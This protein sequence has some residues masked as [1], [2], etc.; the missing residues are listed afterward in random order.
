MNKKIAVLIMSAGKASR[1]GSCKQLVIFNNKGNNVNGEKSTILQHVID[2][3]NSLFQN[4][5]QN[6]VFV[7]TGH[8]HNEIAKQ[9]KST[10][11][12]Y[13]PDW[14]KGLGCS[15]AHGVKAISEKPAMEYDGILI[16]LADQVAIN[17]NHLKQ[18]YGGFN[19][20]NIVCARYQESNGVPALFPRSYFNYLRKLTGDKGAKWLL[21]RDNV[22]R[23]NT[24]CEI[25]S[26]DIQEAGI[27][28]DTPD[29]LKKYGANL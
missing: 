27:D 2:L 15:I 23:C 28:I 5:K 18:I 21:N 9:I 6:D 4:R 7:V 24:E 16:L 14:E 1:F 19:G 8:Y 20:D 26:I 10:Q 12:I 22:N 29:D 13:N 25:F 11:L 3:A 17:E